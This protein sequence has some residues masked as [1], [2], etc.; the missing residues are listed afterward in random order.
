MSCSICQHVDQ[1]AM[2][3]ALAHDSVRTVAER[4]GVSKSTLARHTKVCPTVL[5]PMGQVDTMGQARPPERV[6]H[7]TVNAEARQ[8][9]EAARR[10][11]DILTLRRVVA[12]LALMVAELTDTGERERRLLQ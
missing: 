2:V 9:Y 3:A 7:P 6:H 1:A 10:C 4:Y 8:L 12:E 5:P 11:Y